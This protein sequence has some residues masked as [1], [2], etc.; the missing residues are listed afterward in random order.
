[1]IE[2]SHTTTFLLVRHAETA[3]NKERRHAGSVEVELSDVA[4]RQILKL[5]RTLAHTPIDAIYSSPLSR[6]R[7]TIAPTADLIRLPVIVDDRLIERNLGSWEGKHPEELLPLH[8]GYE[9]PFSAYDGRF[10]IS[11]A[12][13][14]EAIEHRLRTFLNDAHQKHAGQTVV[15]STHSGAIWTILHRIV[16]NPP[17]E[18]FWP[19]NC[20]LTTVASFGNHFEFKKFK[21]LA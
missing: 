10:R 1:M 2:S 9:F 14:L 17:T 12:E 13:T 19:S 3:W 4:P 18:I 15:A 6:S 8:P 11:E 5:T 7:L 20:S 21:A 16:V